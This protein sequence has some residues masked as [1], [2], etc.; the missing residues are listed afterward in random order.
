MTKTKITLINLTAF[1]LMIGSAFVLPRDLSLKVF[2]IVWG[3]LFMGLN[4]G[5]SAKRRKELNKPGYQP[6]AKLYFALALMALVTI[7]QYLGKGR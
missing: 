2:L 4:I 6:S 5:L 3:Y 7:F 1:A